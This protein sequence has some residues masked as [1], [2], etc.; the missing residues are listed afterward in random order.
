MSC[1]PW[2]AT[3]GAPAGNGIKEVGVGGKSPPVLHLGGASDERRNVG[4]QAS[5]VSTPSG[6]GPRE[7]VE[8]MEWKS[9]I[10]NFEKEGGR[11]GW[12]GHW[13]GRQ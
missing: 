6:G 3:D 13:A 11:G 9:R 12:G 10:K 2:A 4:K 5:L 7:V 8:G 1:S